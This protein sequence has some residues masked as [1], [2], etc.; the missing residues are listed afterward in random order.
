V[1][2]LRRWGDGV[3]ITFHIERVVL[4]GVAADHPQQLRRAFEHELIQRLT[5]GGLRTNFS[6]DGLV[7][8]I[9]GGMIK[10]AKNTSAKRLGYEVAHA[11]YHSIGGRR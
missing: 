2:I 1:A 8:Y 4:E 11:V 7:P 5:E 10:V 3:N 6:S 9:R